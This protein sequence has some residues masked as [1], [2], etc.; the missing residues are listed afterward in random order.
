MKKLLL[1]GILLYSA[2]LNAQ[3]GT[4]RGT[5][6]DDA[7]GQTII[8]ANVVIAE[9]LTGAST[10]LDGKFTIEIA[11]GVYDLKISFISFEATTIKGV[12]VTEG[13]VTVIDNIRLQES[14]LA[15]GEVVISAT[16]SRKSDAAINTM[17]KKSAAMMDGISAEKM[18]LTG[19]AT[20]VEAAKRVTGVSI[21]GGKYI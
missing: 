3:K 2:A 1:L 18:A 8:G 6:I 7:T 13:K 14:S 10:D 12:V 21:E 9:P 11:P 16:A 17:K 20:A 5:V 15:L 4:I 19:D